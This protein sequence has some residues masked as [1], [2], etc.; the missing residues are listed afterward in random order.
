MNCCAGLGFDYIYPAFGRSGYDV[1]AEGCED[2]YTCRVLCVLR[3]LFCG[4]CWVDF[5]TVCWLGSEG[6]AGKDALYWFW[7]GDVDQDRLVF[8]EG[9]NKEKTGGC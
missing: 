1:V 6:G 8:E 2:C 9:G 5:F 7:G 3:R 4:Y